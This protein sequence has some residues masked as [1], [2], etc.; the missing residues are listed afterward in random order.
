MADKIA[1]NEPVDIISLACLS[2]H[3]CIC[4]CL[5]LECNNILFV[6]FFW[7]CFFFKFCLLFGCN[8]EYMVFILLKLLARA[9]QKLHVFWCTRSNVLYRPYL[10]WLS[11]NKKCINYMTHCV[12]KR[13]QNWAERNKLSRSNGEGRR[14]KKK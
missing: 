1:I 7:F 2:A 3:F 4:V 9:K 6:S 10:F 14:R 12:R 13:Q 11:I 5:C 8:S